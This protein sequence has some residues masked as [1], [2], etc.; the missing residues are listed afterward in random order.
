MNDEDKDSALRASLARLVTEERRRQ[1]AERHAQ[2][3]ALVAYHAGELSADDADALQDHLAVCPHCAH[4]LLDLDSFLAAPEDVAA[5]RAAP[6]TPG[7][8]V[9]PAAP[10]TPAVGGP[11][12]GRR[13]VARF[14]GARPSRLGLVPY[15]AA[16]LI[17][18]TILAA[19]GW[20]PRLGRPPAARQA[21]LL[22]LDPPQVLRGPEAPP[23]TIVHADA[24]TTILVLHLAQPVPDVRIH[25]QVRADSVTPAGDR[26]WRP[27]EANCAAVEASVA[28]VVLN[29]RQLAPGA[30]QLRV[31]GPAPGP[32][33]EPLGE[34]PL[35]V[36]EP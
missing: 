16:A 14:P 30:Y 12:A 25:L 10:A 3:E 5:T 23:A 13:T 32:A 4:L 8:P 28:V 27:L 20:L 18:M 9:T 35:Q 1:G 31:V 36:V 7:V 26:A 2:P 21:D 17:V 33:A 19:A 15:L 24:V 34:Y 29:R 6:A 22:Q 11:P